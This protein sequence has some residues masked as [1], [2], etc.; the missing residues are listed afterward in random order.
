MKNVAVRH[1]Q[2]AKHR[3]YSI[4]KLQMLLM[5]AVT[6]ATAFFNWVWAYSALIG[7]LI[8]LIPHSYSAFKHFRSPADVTAGVALA[9]VYTGQI[10]KMSLMVVGFVAAFLLIDDLSGFSLFATLMLLQIV[11]FVLQSSSKKIF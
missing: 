4:L 3:Y 2:S 1:N 9:Q 5:I 7:G 8:Y 6:F 11:N 10:W